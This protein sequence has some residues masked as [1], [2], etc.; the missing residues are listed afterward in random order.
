MCFTQGMALTSTRATN[1]QLYSGWLPQLSQLTALTS[2]CLADNCLTEL[3]PL[4]PL[5]QLVCLDLSGNAPLQIAAPL[6]PMLTTLPR[7]RLVDMRAIHEERDNCWS[8]AKCKTMSHVAA[9]AKAM[10][11]RR[12]PGYVKF[13]PH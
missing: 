12:P 1:S 5:K 10:K 6:T 13:C 8:D 4:A 11:R 3:P 2:L 9:L 7:L